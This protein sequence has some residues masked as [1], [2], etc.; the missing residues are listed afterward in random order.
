MVLGETAP[1]KL[2]CVALFARTKDRWSVVHTAPR[3]AGHS[4]TSMQC[5]VINI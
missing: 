4:Q 5:K 3:K 1:D 2:T